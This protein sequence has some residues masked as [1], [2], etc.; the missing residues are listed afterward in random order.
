MREGTWRE[1]VYHDGTWHDQHL[2]GILGRDFNARYRP[3]G[4]AARPLRQP[5]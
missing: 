4:F 2:Y 3:D 5:T 1:H